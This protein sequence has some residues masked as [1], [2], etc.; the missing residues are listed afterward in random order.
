MLSG[1]SLLFAAVVT[2]RCPSLPVQF[3]HNQ[4]YQNTPPC[5]SLKEGRYPQRQDDDRSR[6]SHR[7]S[8]YRVHT[9]SLPPCSIHQ[10][11]ANKK[12]SSSHAP[13]AVAPPK[14]KIDARFVLL[15]ILEPRERRPLPAD[16]Q[17]RRR[18]AQIHH[19]ELLL[20]RVSW[21]QREAPRKV[22]R[23]GRRALRARQHGIRALI[24]ASRLAALRGVSGHP[25]YHACVVHTC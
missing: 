24:I 10:S 9:H 20:R 25:S 19:Y 3:E 7:Q 2:I 16:V 14:H 22:F 8:S 18:H 23:H 13:P 15:A 5:L 4:G 17:T 12:S 21:R 1:L 6:A 11:R